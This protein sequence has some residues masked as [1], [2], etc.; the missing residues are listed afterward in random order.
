MLPTE[1]GSVQEDTARSSSR[2]DPKYPPARRTEQD[3][4]IS[5]LSYAWQKQKQFVVHDVVDFFHVCFDKNLITK[6]I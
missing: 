4:S 5:Y 1:G 6:V 2:R 3:Q